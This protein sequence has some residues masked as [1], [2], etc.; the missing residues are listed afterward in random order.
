[1]PKYRK[2]P[3]VV[4][5]WEFNGTTDSLPPMNHTAHKLWYREHDR[6]NDQ[7]FPPTVVVRTLEGDMTAQV[8]DY[9]IEGVNGEL[10]PCKPDIFS[11]TYDLVEPVDTQGGDA[12]R[13]IMF[14]GWL[15]KQQADK[16]CI[17]PQDPEHELTE[18]EVATLASNGSLC[19]CMEVVQ[20]GG[21]CPIEEGDEFDFG[22]AIHLLKTGK[23]VARKGWNGKNMYLI[24][25][26]GSNDIAKLHGYGFG[27]ALG[28]P[29]FSDAIFLK[30]ADNKLE[31]WTI[32]QSD[33]LAT[34]WCLA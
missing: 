23:T 3:V 18:D 11:K 24:I 10:Y 25:I 17:A 34:D 16:K 22:S 27:E 29:A 20:Y 32:S 28:E 19:D 4:R 5:A 33:A 26:Q 7:H 15:A 1:M 21:D 6:V 30:T 8:G 9:I 13:E 2:K 31:P 12:Y 14:N